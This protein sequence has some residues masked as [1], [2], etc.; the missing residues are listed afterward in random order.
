[1]LGKLIA[2]EILEH[3]MSL[4]FA[5]AC[6]LCLFVVLASFFVRSRDFSNVVDDHEY[7]ERKISDNRSNFRSPWDMRRGRHLV[8]SKPNPLKVFVRGT[9]HT[10][11]REAQ[12]RFDR[13]VEYLRPNIS[14]T[15]IP[16]FPEIDLV[17]FVG[18]ILSLMA[19]V[20]GF[21]AI[22][23]EK[24]RG[25][26]RLVLS[27]SVPRDT[28]LVSKWIGGYISLVAPYLLTVIGLVGLVLAHPN[29]TLD[30]PQ[31]L[32]LTGI[33]GLSLLY[34]AAVYSMALLVST[35]TGR[36]AT[37]IMILVT[38]WVVFFLIVPNLSAPVAQMVRPVPD[39]LDL[40]TQHEQV[41]REAWQELDE[42]LREH[43]E[44][45][46]V[47][48][49]AMNA[50]WSDGPWSDIRRQ[51]V[52][53]QLYVEEEVGAAALEALA[54][55]ETINEPHHA[56]V[57]SQLRLNRWMARFSPYGSFAMAAAELAGE[58]GVSHYQFLDGVKDYQNTVCEHSTKASMFWNQYQLDNQM[59]PYD[60]GTHWTEPFPE[61]RPKSSDQ[62]SYLQGAIVDAGL[63]AGLT[64]VFFLISYV[65]FI[66][67]DVR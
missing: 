37:S 6:V 29:M 45:H 54:R 14:N 62:Y 33:F 52:E 31:W 21:D 53:Y 32:R 67:Y 42:K 61:F 17:I 35:L 1:M 5:I 22:C 20:F 18:L 47:T 28:I 11:A 9:Q 26:L 41:R 12:F 46:N 50:R 10:N 4:R 57:M 63:L 13:P 66:R 16:L 40:Q 23:G 44:T 19:I 7:Q 15:A 59:P 3:L 43:R 36:A 25:T 8:V 60:W 39:V 38:V 51:G 34:L 56:K 24:Q 2:K 49:E 30:A 65:R 55:V 27:Y 64:I 58:G 48:R